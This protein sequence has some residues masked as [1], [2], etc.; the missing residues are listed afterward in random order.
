M[1]IV[2]QV[3]MQVAFLDK[4]VAIGMVE[5]LVKGFAEV[6]NGVAFVHNAALTD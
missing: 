5:V 3:D 1:P 2:Y 6:A 4:I